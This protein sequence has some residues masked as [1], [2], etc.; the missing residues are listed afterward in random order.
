MKQLDPESYHHFQYHQS[1]C[2]SSGIS[3]DIEEVSENLVWLRIKPPA[4]LR[5]IVSKLELRNLALGVFRFLPY[6]PLVTVD[7]SE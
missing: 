5:G 2:A 3:L 1:I 4:E 7:E 6:Q